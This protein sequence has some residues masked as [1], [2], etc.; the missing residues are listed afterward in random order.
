MYVSSIAFSVC[1]GFICRAKYMFERKLFSISLLVLIML[2]KVLWQHMIPHP[3][4]IGNLHLLVP[5]QC[6][7]CVH[8]RLSWLF[9]SDADSF[10]TF[11]ASKIAQ[12]QVCVLFYLKNRCNKRHINVSCSSYFCLSIENEESDIFFQPKENLQYT[13]K[14]DELQICVH[15]IFWHSVVTC[16]I[17]WHSQSSHDFPPELSSSAFLFTIGIIDWASTIT[18]LQV[19]CHASKKVI[20]KWSYPAPLW[21]LNSKDSLIFILIL[22]RKYIATFK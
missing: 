17:F 5:T 7:P 8:V 11:K 4:L 14:K 21:S 3:S 16:Y 9:Y 12:S 2:L 15:F 1:M 18:P 20:L 6:L 13:Y 22:Y 19:F 10:C